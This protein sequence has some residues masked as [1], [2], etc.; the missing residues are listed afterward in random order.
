MTETILI[1]GASGGIGAALA[2]QLAQQGYRLHLVARSHE[3]LQALQQQLA[4]HGHTLT[5]GD[6]TDPSLFARVTAEQGPHLAGLAYCIGNL[7]LKSLRRLQAEDLLGDYQVNAVGAALAVQAALPALKQA[8]QGAAIVLFSSVAAQ[9]GF[10]NHV[11]IG[12]AKA[13]VEGLTRAL[14]AE[15]APR[16]RVNAIAP[17]L[18]RTP[19]AESVLADEKVS[20][21]LAALHPLG[22]LG[23]AQD[24]AAL[25]AFLLS[26]AASWMTGQ[27][28]GVDGGRQHVRSK[29]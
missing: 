22:R 18:S 10:A 26:P 9:V 5:V 14:A 16:I 2:Q 4:G 1:Y 27:I 24:S 20:T 6:V 11:S 17:S 15:L 7:Q 21:A 19:L 12:M 28:I 8:K 13:A 3:R 25:A 29:G 23:E